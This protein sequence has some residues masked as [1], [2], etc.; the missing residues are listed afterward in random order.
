ML[1]FVK[2]WPAEKYFLREAFLFEILTY[3]KIKRANWARTAC[4]ETEPIQE[5]SVIKKRL[6]RVGQERGPLD[7]EHFT[8]GVPSIAFTSSVDNALVHVLNDK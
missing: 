3:F 2:S 6:P 1:T 7:M 5:G 8:G 4:F